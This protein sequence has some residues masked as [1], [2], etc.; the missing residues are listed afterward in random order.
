MKNFKLSLT[1]V[2]IIAF[3]SLLLAGCGSSK[4]DMPSDT[5]SEYTF[6]IPEETNPSA[7]NDEPIE[8]EEEKVL[9]LL[10]Q[11]M[12]F[13]EGIA[14]VL[15]EDPSGNE[16][17]GWLHTDGHIDQPFPYDTVAQ[18]K[19]DDPYWVGLGSNFS[20]GYSYVKT[21]DAF[22]GG[23]S[24]SPDSFLILNQK[25]E[26]TAQSPDDGSSYEILCGGDGVYLVKQ[27]VRNMT[28]NED[29][30]GFISGDG[31]WINE[32]TICE[33]GGTH[34]L[35]LDVVPGNFDNK[36]ISFSYLGEGI[37]QAEYHNGKS[38]SMYY[39]RYGVV[40]YNAYTK[41]NFVVD[42]NT[43][44]VFTDS[45]GGAV[46][47]YSDGFVPVKSNGE[48]YMLSAD[49][50]KKPLTVNSSDAMIYSEG[51]IFSGDRNYS[52]NRS[53]YLTNGKF[54]HTDGSVLAD[55]SQYE[56]L[57]EDTYD[58]YRFSDG[59]AAIIICGA[60][61]GQYLG[62][63]DM[64]GQ[65]SFEP[66]KIESLSNWDNAGKFASG[67]IVCC[68][69]ENGI[70]IVDIGGVQTS[71]AY[72]EADHVENY[73]FSEGFACMDSYYIGTD[74]NVLDVFVK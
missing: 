9:V 73:V 53:T 59:Y 55:L 18:L 2:M 69:A 45:S 32:C 70:Q 68:T 66:I 56:L 1:S 51:V 57:Y 48:L 65:F 30:Y 41:Q 47:N 50:E 58:L 14:W 3:F 7:I 44:S 52:G 4:T 61:G 5:S 74:G 33:A 22:V 28:I 71:S 21:G 17:V 64:D 27:S 15:Y 38:S 60:D 10:K 6:E 37:F 23:A 63:I 49:F 36:N 26:I 16:Q 39:H 25:G 24:E 40:L 29:R 11:A 35:S 42:S 72:F 62:I 19:K 8:S 43:T 34:P 54:Y 67:V 31:N 20:G 12:P 13:S 46:G